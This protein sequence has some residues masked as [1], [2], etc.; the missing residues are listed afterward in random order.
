MAPWA[1]AV[2][3]ALALPAAAAGPTADGVPTRA[4]VVAGQG[5]VV[6]L[7]ADRGAVGATGRAD[8]AEPGPSTADSLVLRDDLGRTV[9]LP[10]PPDR[11]V[12]LVPAA[13]ELLFALDAGDRLVGRT[14]YGVHPPAAR[15]VPSVGQGIRPSLELVLERR[16]GLVLLF[17]GPETRGT[18]D[19]LEELGVPT[20]ALRH[21]SFSD[22]R[23]NVRRLGR[24]T[25]RERAAGELLGTIRCRLRRVAGAVRGRPRP[26]VYYEV[27]SDPPVTVGR[28]SYL[29]SLLSVAGARNVFGDL[30]APSPRVGLEAVAAR[31]PDL[32]LV[33]R[34]GGGD[35]GPR[36]ARRPGW[37][38]V[39]AVREGRVRTVDG[40]LVHRLGPRVGQAAGALA[41]V[42]HPGREEALR[43]LELE[44]CDSGPDAPAAD[45]AVPEPEAEAPS[46]SPA[47][48]AARPEPGTPPPAPRR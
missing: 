43:S 33:P 25:G 38:V 39:P 1:G 5:D 3:L 48:P 26:R 8:G 29:D 9:R 36:P 2:V 7:P 17:A 32:V 44:R 27:W 30:R 47:D 11:I 42:I 22:L 20:L 6:P 35:G 12:S 45:R 21:N 41:T 31:D 34:R 18:A 24:L 4:G 13:T 10:G 46:A 40:D 15:E 19:R 28:G 37:D 23:R 16:P 14:R